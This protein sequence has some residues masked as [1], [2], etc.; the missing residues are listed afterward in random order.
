MRVH[1]SGDPTLEQFDQWTLSVGNGDMENLR[2]PDEMIATTIIPNSTENRTSEGQG[3]EA[4][5]N[6]VFPNL[7]TNVSNSQWLEG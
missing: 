2:I 4:F 1:A 6:E 5:C 7:E 3:M